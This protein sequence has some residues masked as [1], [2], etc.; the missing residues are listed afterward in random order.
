VSETKKPGKK[1]MLDF[2]EGR[3]HL[4]KVIRD[5]SILLKRSDEGK[6][7]SNSEL[8]KKA[9]DDVT[10]GVVTEDEINKATAKAAKSAPEKEEEGEEK[11]VKEEK[12]EKPK[13]KG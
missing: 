1:M 11:T 2:K 9:M 12:D 13:K 5:W 10:S 4:I 8:I 6:N 3:F 7:L